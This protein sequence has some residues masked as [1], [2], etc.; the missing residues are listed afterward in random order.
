MNC[1]AKE[2]PLGQTCSRKDRVGDLWD[3]WDSVNVNGNMVTEPLSELTGRAIVTCSHHNAKI[4]SWKG[5]T[6]AT[7]L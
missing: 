1:D 3:L 7:I 6:T 4:G 2:S 5:Y